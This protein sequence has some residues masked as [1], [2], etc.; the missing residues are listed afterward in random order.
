MRAPFSNLDGFKFAV[1]RESFLSR[2]QKF[3]GARDIE[4]GDPDFDREYIVIGTDEGKARELFSNDKIR[5]TLA[6]RRLEVFKIKEGQ[7][8]AGSSLLSTPDELHFIINDEYENKE[9]LKSIF[10][11]FSETLDQLERMGTAEAIGQKR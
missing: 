10:A 4:I 6:L 1:V 9:R 3:L 2:I 7:A 8:A 11:L 5:K